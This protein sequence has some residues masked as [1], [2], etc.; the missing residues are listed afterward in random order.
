MRVA[1]FRELVVITPF[2]SFEYDIWGILN[3]ENAM[4]RGQCQSVGL[5]VLLMVMHVYW[6]IEEISSQRHIGAME[7]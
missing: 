2:D 5:N 1:F 3:S 4:A 6:G 7:V